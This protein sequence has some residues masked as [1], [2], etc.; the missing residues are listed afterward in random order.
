MEDCRA[1]LTTHTV[2]F[3]SQ[4]ASLARSDR[5]LGQACAHLVSHATT[6]SQ[7]QSRTAS[8]KAAIE[9]LRSRQGSLE[10]FLDRIEGELPAV[11]SALGI[12][13]P[14]A[15]YPNDEAVIEN[16]AGNKTSIT[17]G[18]EGLLEGIG[19]LVEAAGATLVYSANATST[20]LLSTSNPP[21]STFLMD[22]EEEEEESE[23]G[24]A[25]LTAILDAHLAALEHLAER[26]ELSEQALL[27]QSLG[28]GQRAVAELT[29]RGL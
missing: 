24:G 23:M 27:P 17:A 3:A 19:A 11:C 14:D 18:T 13:N 29:R 8:L 9:E 16:R 10:D 26:V 4:A 2:T 28:L 5:A 7:T 15:D 25:R 21:Q 1:A 22:E 6:L 12:P 20:K